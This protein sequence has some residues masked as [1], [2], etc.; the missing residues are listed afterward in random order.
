MVVQ[1][2]SCVDGVSVD[3]SFEYKITNIIDETRRNKFST[4]LDI[5]M[6]EYIMNCLTS[7]NITTKKR[8][9]YYEFFIRKDLDPYDD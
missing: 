3:S 1:N 4:E 7:F 6:A 5:I 9:D 8:D 2:V